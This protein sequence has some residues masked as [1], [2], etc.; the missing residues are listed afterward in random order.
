MRISLFWTLAVVGLVG[1]CSES[2]APSPDQ[3]QNHLSASKSRSGY[4]C[5]VSG[6]E[7]YA[8][9]VNAAEEIVVLSA[10][11]YDEEVHGILCDNKRGVSIDLGGLGG[12]WTSPDALNASGQVVGESETADAHYHAFFWDHGVM[13]DLGTLPGDDHSAAHGISDNGQV[14]GESSKSSYPDI[15]QFRH[16]FL[17]N[18]GRLADLGTLPDMTWSVANAINARGQVVGTSGTG[19]PNTANE[20]FVW[21]H[22]QMT[23]LPTL[24]GAESSASDINAAGQIVGGAQ[25]A[26]G[27]WHAVVWQKGTVTDL[28]PGVATAINNAGVVVGGDTTGAVVYWRNGVKVVLQPASSEEDTYSHADAISSSGVVVGEQI[29]GASSIPMV[30]TIR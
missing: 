30:W 5:D 27:E 15:F 12:T 19:W 18:K 13:T 17:W 7:V 24:G 4:T 28:G 21:Q 8:G 6:Y 10:D 23:P 2:T 1:G 9:D 20:A 14:V 16:A 3:V 29:Y 25:T 26:S 11:Y 22:G